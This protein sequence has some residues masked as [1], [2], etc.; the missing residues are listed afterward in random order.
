MLARLFSRSRPQRQGPSAQLPEGQ[1]VYAVGDVHGMLEQ[2]EELLSRIEA[3]NE[4][5]GPARTTVIFLGDLIDRGPDSAQVV[6]RLREIA[7]AS[8]P[9]TIRFLLGNHEEVLLSV[10]NGSE[11]ALRFFN[12]IGGRETL[13]SYG[14]PASVYASCEYSELLARAQAAVPPEHVE[15]LRGFEDM[16]VLGDYAFVHAGVDPRRALDEQETAHLRWIRE[17]FLDHRGTLEKVVV[18]G[19]TVRDDVEQLAHRIGIDTGAFAGGPLTA[20]GFEGRDRWVLQAP[21][22]AI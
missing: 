14:I 18:H 17:E 21:P 16:I 20:M 11:K 8:T 7:A 15:F 22:R 19:H 1:R 2:L 10:L 5:R 9:G 4:A 3:D 6:E 13:L 12:R